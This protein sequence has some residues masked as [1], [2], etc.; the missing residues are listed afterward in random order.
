MKPIR[1]GKNFLMVANISGK[2]KISLGI[3]LLDKTLRVKEKTIINLS[4]KID[5]YSLQDVDYTTAG[6]IVLLG[7]EYE[8]TQIGKKKRKRYVFQA[9]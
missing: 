2:E 9:I 8:L 7:K 5:E 4:Q 3:S 6:K 1:N